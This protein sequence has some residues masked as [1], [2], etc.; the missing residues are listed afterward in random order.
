VNL[1][2]MVGAGAL[3]SGFLAGSFWVNAQWDREK[4]AQTEQLAAA[5][6]KAME[7]SRRVAVAQRAKDN[8]YEV[9]IRGIGGRLADALERLRKRP[10]RLP[11]P[12][13][14]ACAGATG[15]ELSGRDAAFLE[16]LAARAD[17]L[18]AALAR[19]QGNQIEGQPQPTGQVT[20]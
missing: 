20:P 3:V 8:A 1:T 15:S 17:E 13:R 16:R 11:E 4:L 19:C 18:R 10:E 6:A 14:A 2:L 7:D 5:Q 9:Q 12:A